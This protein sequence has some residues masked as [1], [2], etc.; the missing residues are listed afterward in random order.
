VILAIVGM[1]GSGKSV[2]AK[3]LRARGIPAVRFGQIITDEVLG[4]GLPLT[5]ENEQLVREDL[6]RVYGMDVCA[7][8]S[9]PMLR[10][11]LVV[12][13]NVGIDGLYS[14]GEFKTLAA[15]FGNKLFVIA[16]AAPRKTRYERLAKRAERPLSAAEALNRDY[17][18]IETLEKGGPIA[19]ADLTITNDASEQELIN[20][21]EYALASLQSS[22]ES[23]N[24]TELPIAQYRTMTPSE[25]LAYLQSHV[26]ENNTTDLSQNFVL[27]AL[28]EEKDPALQWFLVKAIGILRLSHG[29][30][31]ILRVCKS[32]EKDMRHT[33][34]HA[35]CAWSLGRIGASAFD[36]VI[37]L[38]K[39]PDPETRR[40]AVDSL[41]E[42]ADKRAIPSLCT[43][44][45]RDE[46]H[47]QLWAGLSLAKM[48]EAALPCLERL[49][50]APDERVRL[51]ASDAIGKIGRKEFAAQ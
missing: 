13:R 43:A 31:E 7:R 32:P 47:V 37:Q 16:I 20:K 46:H 17:R 24:M 30:P 15:E 10:E 41:G 6:R 28:A 21:V 8:R 44:L 1:P 26:Q 49:A 18:E 38:L 36:S 51:I 50:K 33:S 48:G 27:Q 42:I 11:L 5:P 29:I 19:I 9:L 4:R 14:F 12:H 45:E 34:L 39:N 35:I 3:H 23:E 22:Q 25:R 2:V 40:C